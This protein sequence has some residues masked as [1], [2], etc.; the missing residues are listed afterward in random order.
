MKTVILTSGPR[1]AGKSGFVDMILKQ[2]PEIQLISRDAILMELFGDTAL[3]PYTGGHEYAF[4]VMWDRIK[5]T[6]NKY[7]E[8]EDFTMILDCWNGYSQGRRHIVRRLREMGVDRVS[9]WYFITPADVCVRWFASKP[10]GDSL[11]PTS[12][13]RD[14]GFYHQQ[15]VNI[16]DD[17]FDSVQEIN[18][19]QLLI[20]GF[21][22][23]LT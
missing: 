8:G 5:E 22:T 20:P 11:S 10:D 2:Q 23:L 17:G 6:L 7:K 15:A 4:C 9:C 3:S 13:R 16:L 21:A 14:H 18:P 1:G 12:V 19:L